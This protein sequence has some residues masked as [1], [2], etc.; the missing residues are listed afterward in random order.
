MQGQNVMLVDFYLRDLEH[1]LL[2]QFVELERT[3]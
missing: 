2:R 1:D 3:H